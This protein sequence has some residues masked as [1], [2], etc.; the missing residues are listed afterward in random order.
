V[1]RSGHAASSLLSHRPCCHSPLCRWNYKDEA[2]VKAVVGRSAEAIARGGGGL[3]LLSRSGRQSSHIPLR[4]HT[5]SAT[6]PFLPP[7]RRQDAGFD[8]H[9]IPYDVLWL[10]IEHT[11]GKR[12]GGG[13]RPASTCRWGPLARPSRAPER[14]CCLLI[15]PSC[16]DPWAL[17]TPL[18]PHDRHPNPPTKVHDLGRRPLP[19]PKGHAGRPRGARPQDG[20]DRRPPRWVVFGV[21][22]EHALDSSLA[23][24]RQL[25]CRRQLARP[26]RASLQQGLCCHCPQCGQPPAAVP[27]HPSPPPQSSA[28][29]PTASTRRPP[30]RA[31][32]SR[33]RT[34]RTLRVG[35]GLVRA[36]GRRVVVGR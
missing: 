9:A 29:R 22:W 5:L 30:S 24:G 25:P 21:E 1:P 26:P 31:I 10:D 33:T 6:T 36:L 13:A 34:G 2:D 12:C 7:C 27:A 11:D 23:A 14:A 20:R 35:A 28:T 17:L 16:S 18:H 3:P 8:E 32:T 4:P 15:R 19:H